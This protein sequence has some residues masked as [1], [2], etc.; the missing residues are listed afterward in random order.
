M[1]DGVEVLSGT[2]YFGNTRKSRE[3]AA[4][5]MREI[6]RHKHLS[7]QKNLGAIAERLGVNLEI[8]P[9]D[10]TAIY[11]SMPEATDPVIKHWQA[12]RHLKE[13]AYA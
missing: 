10:Y 13:V 4:E 12:S 1:K 3:L 2:I 6:E 8:L 5:W 11:D 7:D 9:A